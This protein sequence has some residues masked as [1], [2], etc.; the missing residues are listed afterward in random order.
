MS[1]APGSGG[2]SMA[3]LCEIWARAL[4]GN[5]EMMN[6]KIIIIKCISAISSK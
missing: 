5:T 1:V 2:L 3:T 4:N 6:N